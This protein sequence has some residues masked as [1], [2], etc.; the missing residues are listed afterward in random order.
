MAW[1]ARG[2]T[3]TVLQAIRT[4]VFNASAPMARR[5]HFHRA[6]EPALSESRR[7]DAERRHELS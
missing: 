3:D 4:G 2:L 6:P 1:K 7:D 5:G